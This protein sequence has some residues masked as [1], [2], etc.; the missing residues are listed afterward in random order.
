MGVVKRPS[1]TVQAII[2]NPEQEL[3]RLDSVTGENK[4][5]SEH[6]DGMAVCVASGSFNLQANVD[7]ASGG[8][9]IGADLVGGLNQLLCLFGAEPFGT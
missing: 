8:V 6:S 9:G 2:A 1:E 3:Y 7:I 5:P 4:M